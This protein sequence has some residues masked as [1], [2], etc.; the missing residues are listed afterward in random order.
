MY[1]TKSHSSHS[2]RYHEKKGR[3]RQNGNNGCVAASAASVGERSDRGERIK[4]TVFEK[5][6]DKWRYVVGK[7]KSRKEQHG[8]RG[9]NSCETTVE[10]RDC[11]TKGLVTCTRRDE[12]EKG[13]KVTVCGGTT[14]RA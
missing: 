1:F 11:R 8:R 10:Q 5:L 6:M 12:G 13:D 14:V 9:M 4:G 7:G 2:A 3:D